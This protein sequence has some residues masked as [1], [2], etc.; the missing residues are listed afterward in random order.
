M[1]QCGELLTGS[2]ILL[3]GSGLGFAFGSDALDVALGVQR[4]LLGQFLDPGCNFGGLW[5]LLQ[6]L[7]LLHQIAVLAL[8]IQPQVFLARLGRLYA[9][10]YSGSLLWRTHQWLAKQVEFWARRS[11]GFAWEEQLAL[12]PGRGSG[13]R[14]GRLRTSGT[15]TKRQIHEALHDSAR[16]AA[17]GSLLTQTFNEFLL[18]LVY[19]TGNQ[20]L[21]EARCSFLGGFF[22]A[23]NHGAFD[24]LNPCSFGCR[25][26]TRQ[27]T[28]RCERFQCA[29]D[30]A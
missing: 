27:N 26:D 2:G 6:T 7:T 30:G 3:S 15:S 18:R 14:L 17:V 10:L 13:G 20:V 8:E 22:T 29:G 9:F 16:C 19:A 5:L 21:G 24:C 1:G 12:S 23:S 4:H 25:G 11:D 28:E